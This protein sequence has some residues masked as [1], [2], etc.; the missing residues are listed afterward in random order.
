MTEILPPLYA[1]W[2]RE[3]LG[4]SIPEEAEA[5]CSHCVMLSQDHETLYRSGYFF[6][7]KTKCCTYIPVLPNFL[8]GA[9]L[10]DKEHQT[11]GRAKL[12]EQLKENVAA[13]PLNLNRSLISM[14]LYKHVSSVMGFGRSRTI[15]CPFYLEGDGQC[16]IWRHRES[17]CATWFCKHVRGYTGK[18]FWITLQ[19]LLAM[20]EKSLA[21]WCVLELELS[22][23]A[24]KRL[25]TNFVDAYQVDLFKTSEA[26]IGLS[27][28]VYQAI[29]GKW[30]GHEAEFYKKCAQLVKAL[31]WKDITQICGP[32]A[33]V[34]GNLVHLAYEQLKSEKIPPA[35]HVGEYQVAKMESDFVRVWSYSRLDPLDLPKV[36]S[37][38]LHYFN[39]RPVME[40]LK[41]ISE[42][43][44]IEIDKAL[45]RKLI[46]FRILLP[47]Q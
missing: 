20:I 26:G 4:G 34:Y 15:R 41:I 42:K 28:S 10:D 3:L 6:D 9:I 5:K 21:C 18:H 7:S 39:G 29:W 43:E 25:F 38:I 8:I 36:L 12:E 23:E 32:E 45:L 30:Y 27:Q 47:K 2:M 14:L 22:E 44:D 1:S 24:M 37:D 31:T 33:R 40:A 13:N 46:D 19:Q 17:T 11:P 16:G 35:L